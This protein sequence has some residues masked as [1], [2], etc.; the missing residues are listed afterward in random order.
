[1]REGARRCT[2]PAPGQEGTN[3]FPFT[4]H[5]AREG[6]VTFIYLLFPRWS[7]FLVK[8]ASLSAFC[9]QSQTLNIC[10]ISRSLDKGGEKREGGASQPASPTP[11]CC[12]VLAASSHSPFLWL[13]CGLSLHP[14]VSHGAQHPG[15][16]WE[17]C[18]GEGVVAL[19]TKV[20]RTD[21]TAF[22]PR[23][24]LS[25]VQVCVPSVHPGNTPDRESGQL[26]GE[27]QV[28]AEGWEWGVLSWYVW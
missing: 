1:M 23:Y 27:E 21:M 18:G 8:H 11:L 3:T 25:V 20:S 9:A 13:S 28:K 22:P 15:T 14:L 24:W 2:K 10:P 4:E 7:S 17:W 5:R 19:Q 6:H 12:F 26:V 16:G